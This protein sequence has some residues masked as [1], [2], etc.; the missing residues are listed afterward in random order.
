MNDMATE[1]SNLSLF[2]HFQ[3]QNCQRR[4]INRENFNMADLQKT[5]DALTWAKEF[6]KLNE[7]FE[8]NE[9]MEQAIS[10]WLTAYKDNWERLKENKSCLT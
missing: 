1:D 4:L 6:I 8:M 9:Y 3:I 2:E 10:I 7:M 5:T